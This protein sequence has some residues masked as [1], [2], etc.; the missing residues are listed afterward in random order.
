MLRKVRS[1]SFSEAT[2]HERSYDPMSIKGIRLASTAGEKLGSGRVTVGSGDLQ[3]I[4][5]RE[6]G[7]CPGARLDRKGTTIPLTS[8]QGTHLQDELAGLWRSLACKTLK[9]NGRSTLLNRSYV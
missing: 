8:P 4:P 1:H 5:K 7:E 6:A 9:P 3:S 2:L